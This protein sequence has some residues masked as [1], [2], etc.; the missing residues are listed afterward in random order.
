M[1]LS[2]LTNKLVCFLG[3]IFIGKQFKTYYLIPFITRVK[4]LIS[5]ATE[6][7]VSHGSD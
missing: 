2:K 4:K 7:D 6:S 3:Q 1:V 5:D